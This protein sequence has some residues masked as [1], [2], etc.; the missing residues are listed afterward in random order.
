MKEKRVD[1][2]DQIARNKR[3]SFFLMISVFIIFVLIGYVISLATDP[4]YFFIIMS[5]TIFL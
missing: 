2:R 1:F 4:G 3:K 5:L